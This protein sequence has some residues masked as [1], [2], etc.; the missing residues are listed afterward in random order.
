LAKQ[1]VID[2]SQNGSPTVSATTHAPV[3][4]PLEIE[5]RRPLVSLSSL[6]FVV[7]RSRDAAEAPLLVHV[8]TATGGVLGMI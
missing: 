3:Y 1:E 7:D 2:T 6:V 8:E 5:H 4:V